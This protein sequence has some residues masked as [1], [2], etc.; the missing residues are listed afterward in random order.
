MAEARKDKEYYLSLP[1]TI[2]LRRDEEGDFV[3]RI[4]ELAGCISHGKTSQEALDNVE[5]VK[6]AW[7][8]ECIEGGQTVPEPVPEESLPSGKWVQ[9]VPRSLHKKLTTL[10]KKEGVS[11]NALVTSELSQVV[12]MREVQV[13]MSSWPEHFHA[14]EGRGIWTWATRRRTGRKPEYKGIKVID[15]LGEPLIKLGAVERLTQDIK[16]MDYDY[17]EKRKP[18]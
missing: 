4:E 1:Y 16:V 10:A 13:P 2:I 9:R 15:V 12:G 7:I 18:N 17:K 8:S 3:A 11:L 14:G 6:E 5:E